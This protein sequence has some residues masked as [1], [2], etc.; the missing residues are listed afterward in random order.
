VT[1]EPDPP[2][3]APEEP[4]DAA[5]DL[6]QGGLRAGDSLGGY[7]LESE[8]ARGGMGVVYRARD[9]AL[10]RTVALKVIATSV[11]HDAVF[12]Q[13]FERE[14]RAAARL[15]HPNAVPVYR[16]GEDDGRLFL[17]MR[18]IDGRDLATEVRERSGLPPL[19]AAQIISQVAGALDAA[20][21]L[22][23]VHRDVKPANILLGRQDGTVQS[24]LA[25]FG[26]TVD[27]DAQAGLTRTGQVVGTVAYMAP[28]RIRGGTVDSGADVYALGGVLHFCL[29][30]LA[31]YP[32]AHDLDALSAHLSQPPPKPSDHG[33]PR[34][35]DEVVAGAMAKEVSQRS[36]SAGA[37]GRAALAAARVDET[38][39]AHRDVGIGDAVPRAQR[40]APEPRTPRWK[41]RVFVALAG[42]GAV[43]VAG[44]LALIQGDGDQPAGEA[45][46]ARPAA[47]IKLPLPPEHVV[48]ARGFIWTATGS[49]RRIRVDP[50]ARAVSQ[51]GAAVDLVGGFY[52]DLD[53]G[54]GG[55][56]TTQNYASTG[57]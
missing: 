3:V 4:T 32:V 46:R 53:A 29:T 49:G 41:A 45:A 6:A 48:V 2:A 35:F 40:P 37:V 51:L 10:G 22:G 42:A 13:R 14:W 20:H 47:P 30:G 25:D 36:P 15:E 38:A 18:F 5:F 55:V 21:A 39:R 44:L 43:A 28:E 17:A 9:E 31:P 52:P 16:A 33:A 57:G 23:L 24:Y 56:W 1:S 12:R 26:L 11:A 34:S 8:V 7:V 19:E 50:R 54:A 27:H